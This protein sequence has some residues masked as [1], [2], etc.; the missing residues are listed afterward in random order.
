MNIN[1]VIHIFI[2]T[3]N[4]FRPITGA[5]NRI[6][7]AAVRDKEKKRSL[8]EKDSA[9]P[10]LSGFVI[11]KYRPSFGGSDNATALQHR[12][13]NRSTPFPACGDTAAGRGERAA[14]V[15]TN[16]RRQD[17]TTDGEAIPLR[18]KTF[19]VSITS[20]ECCAIR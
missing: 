20:P 4:A 13:L 8:P 19:R 10:L 7:L 14:S 3:Q 1:R 6:S 11:Y 12:R 5:D 17:F 9:R 18:W 16:R 2:P 15:V